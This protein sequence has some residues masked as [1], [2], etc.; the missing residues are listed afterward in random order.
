MQSVMKNN[1][2]NQKK[3]ATSNSLNTPYCSACHKAGKSVT[4]YTNHWMKSK[5]QQQSTEKED[6]ITCPLILNST[7]GYCKK[8][9]HWTKYCPVLKTK[10]N[11]DALLMK[12]QEKSQR[13]KEYEQSNSVSNVLYQNKKT[14]TGTL[15]AHLYESDDEDSSKRK[16]KSKSGGKKIDINMD[17]DSCYPLL[18]NGIKTKPKPKANSENNA[19]QSWLS[20]VNNT[21]QEVVEQSASA[22]EPPKTDIVEK[23]K[24]ILYTNTSASI[25]NIKKSKTVPSS[26]L[27]RKRSWVDM[28]MDTSSDE[29]E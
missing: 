13:K 6:V 24:E 16:S 17:M 11:T 29:E 4:E 26:I 21:H 2:A 9:G 12:E 7:C 5:T 28:E 18:S 19:K 22:D 20:V 23:K 25:S 15:F 1:Q 14:V 27:N 3:S 10:N 8:D